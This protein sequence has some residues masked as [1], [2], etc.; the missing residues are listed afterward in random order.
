MVDS[1][2]QRIV[3]EEEPVRVSRLTQDETTTDRQINSEY[4]ISAV[5]LEDGGTETQLT[6]NRLIDSGR[7]LR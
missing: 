7:G 6:T 5:R 2:R 1:E 4:K 3:V